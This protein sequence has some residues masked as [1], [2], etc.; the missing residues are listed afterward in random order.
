M[1]KGIRPPASPATSAASTPQKH[2]RLD[3][4]D[5]LS[6]TKENASTELSTDAALIQD[7]D[8]SS[9]SNHSKNHQGNAVESSDVSLLRLADDVIELSQESDRL[10]L[11]VKKQVGGIKT[12]QHRKC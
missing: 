3:L 11:L 7:N 5:S 10:A 9:Q 12:I 1:S 8:P 6:P 4:T 2:R